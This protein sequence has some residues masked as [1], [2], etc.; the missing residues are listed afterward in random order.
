MVGL[1]PSV[2]KVQ[3]RERHGLTPEEAKGGF[4]TESP[5]TRCCTFHGVL[6]TAKQRGFIPVS[7]DMVIM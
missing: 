1:K 6:Q 4:I 2:F 3:Q 7:Q 5:N